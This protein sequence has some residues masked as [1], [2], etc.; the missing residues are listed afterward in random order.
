MSPRRLHVADLA[1]GPL[2]LRGEPCHYLGRVLRLPEGTEV[3]LFDGRGHEAVA[4]LRE[5][6]PDRLRL[7]VGA[8]RPPPPRGAQVVLVVALLKGEKMDLV[9]QKATELGVDAIHAVATERAVVR[10]DD[11]RAAGRVSRWER[12]AAEAARQS[13]RADVPRIAPP[14]PL[15]A[16][17][18][19]LR[20]PT[21]A[22]LS[23][24][25]EPLAR[26]RGDIAVAVGPEGGFTPDE[27]GL[28][29]ASGWT[30]CTLGDPILRAETAAIAIVSGLRLFAAW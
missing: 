22:I 16:T 8:L 10:L 11:A 30:A 15:A 7:E 2:E 21:R 20:T 26:P 23:P 25:G 17:L 9:V 29:L 4:I 12:I 18:R 3:V 28:A 6:G 19:E 27:I 14:G 5:I 13:G 1:A 24:G